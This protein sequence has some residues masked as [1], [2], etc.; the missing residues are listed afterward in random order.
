MERERIEK[1]S[2]EWIEKRKRDKRELRRQFEKEGLKIITRTLRSQ[3][4]NYK[5][6]NPHSL[7]QY[8][9]YTPSEQCQLIAYYETSPRSS[10]Q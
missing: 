6:F 10:G 3:R 5:K 4:I 8:N 1:A 2:R 9:L 7:F